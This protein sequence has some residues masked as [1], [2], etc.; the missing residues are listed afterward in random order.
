[1][2]E[3]GSGKWFILGLTGLT[4]AT[5][6]FTGGYGAATAKQYSEASHPDYSNPTDSAAFAEIW[7]ILKEDYLVQPVVDKT[8]YYGTLHGLA[9]A[10]HDPYTVFLAPDEKELLLGQ[11]SGAFEG[12]GAEIGQIE[13]QIVV[14]SPLAGSPA[15][16]A[17]L[18]PKDAILE[19][20]GEDTTNLSIDQAILKIRG[21]EGTTVVLTIYREGE[22]DVREIELTRAKIEVPSSNYETVSAANGA[23]IGVLT[24][25]SVDETSAED[26]TA[27]VHDILLNPPSGLILDLRNNP[28][29]V[30]GDSIDIVSLFINGGPVVSEEF[31]DGST[32]I[33]ETT[34]E[35]LL[36][37][38]P[39]MVVLINS[40]SASAAEIIAG[41]LQDKQRAWVIGTTSFGK[42][43]VQNV[44]EFPD[45][46]A[47]KFT[48][49][50]WLTPNGRTIQDTGIT[51]DETVENTDPNADAQLQAALEYLTQ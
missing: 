22:S 17:G 36:P 5:L 28:G 31:N 12:I 37:N 9:S 35:P 40:G 7:K 43:V 3:S 29:G 13:G 18:L 50:H 32:Q 1:M 44:K 26:V 14:I 39:K 49:S 21:P 16:A 23:S 15:E 41:A 11:V 2:S 10:V 8:L 45:G 30:L 25:S 27:Q 4:I 34:G 33:Y 6:A 20:D 19:I 42:G 24:L 38:D 51:P 48:V 46:S 47:L